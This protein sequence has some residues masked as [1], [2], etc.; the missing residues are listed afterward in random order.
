MRDARYC[1]RIIGR[2][3]IIAVSLSALLFFAARAAWP[4]SPTTRVPTVRAYLAVFLPLFLVTMLVVDPGLAEERAHI[5]QGALDSNTR[6]AMGFFFLVTVTAAA[7]DVGRLHDSDFVPPVLSLA[8]LALLA[9][10][11]AL[12]AWAMIVN[13]FF[14]P[15]IRVQTER[16][17][18]VITR[19]PY[20]CLR[21]PGYLAM[22]IIVPAS[23]LAIGS[24]L[25]LIPAA[26]FII[27]TLRRARLED[28]FLQQHLPGYA[29]YAQSVPKRLFPRFTAL[30]AMALVLAGL[31]L[32]VAAF[33][34]ASTANSTSNLKLS[35]SP[36]NEQRAF[37]DLK[38][39][40]AFGPR[41]LGSPGHDQAEMYICASL[42]ASGVDL[43][44]ATLDIFQASTPV[45]SIEMT[46][47][48]GVIPGESRDIIMLAGHYDTKRITHFVGANDGASSAAFLLEMARVLAQRTNPVT[49]W[50]VFFDGEEALRNWSGTDSRYGSRHLRENLTATG[51]FQ[52]IRA[53]ILVDMIGDRNLHIHRD[54]NS[55]PHLTD[56]VFHQA[57]A[58]G[59]GAYFPDESV[60]IE[61]DHDS[62]TRKT[63][64]SDGAT[65]SGIPA[66]DLISTPF[67]PL[68]F[69]WHSRFDTPDKCSPASLG[70][71]GRVILRVLPILERTPPP[72]TPPQETQPQVLPTPI[73]EASPR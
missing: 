36:F 66:I 46:N 19:G 30:S 33:A 41:S 63:F 29:Q 26:G 62:F 23:A 6:F 60:A 68:N 61:D 57:R 69:Y 16:G 50:I 53:M 52:K 13:P 51:E 34:Y 5:G 39:L 73:A 42:L 14:S 27:V 44:H 9:V 48:I 1:I 7:L 3:L 28:Q 65:V 35:E 24:W 45:G 12:Q 18:R 59:Y 71:V 67:G 56:L 32:L 2:W 40:T 8:A 55:D 31:A 54:S 49:Y 20:R 17:H 70:I 25:A 15:V 64:K 43:D 4:L 37:D 11:I 58:L 47:V 22:L 38:A 10:S 72:G 21:H